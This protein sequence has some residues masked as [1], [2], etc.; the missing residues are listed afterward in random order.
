ML[1]IYITKK[2]ILMKYIYW[3]YLINGYCKINNG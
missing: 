3:L 2:N 1:V